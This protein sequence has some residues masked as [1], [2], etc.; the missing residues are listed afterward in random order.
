M[1]L[2]G[3][4]KTGDGETM[5]K[6]MPLPGLSRGFFCPLA[7]NLSRQLVGPLELKKGATRGRGGDS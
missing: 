3:S 2:E 1:V 6:R 5:S 4:K 7:S